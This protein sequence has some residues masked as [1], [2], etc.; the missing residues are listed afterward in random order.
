MITKKNQIKKPYTKDLSFTNNQNESSYMA[1]KVN[2]T[3]NLQTQHKRSSSN[4]KKINSSKFLRNT[5]ESKKPTSRSKKPIMGSIITNNIA[6]Q[7]KKS[8]KGLHTKLKTDIIP[9][10]PSEGNKPS[11]IPNSFQVIKKPFIVKT[12]KENSISE[13]I[14]NL[15]SD[16]GIESTPQYAMEYI[17]DIYSNLL[18]EEKMSPLKP[19]FG[20]MAHQGEINEQMRAILIDWII[21]VHLKFHFNEETLYLTIRIIDLYLSLVPILRANLQLLGV[22][23]L[24]IACKEEEI[25]FP[26]IKEYVYITDNAYTKEQILAME[27]HVLKV[28]QFNI[29]SPSPL[30]FYEIISLALGFDK[31]LFYFGRFLME[32]FIIDY[33][34]T[35]YSASVIASSCAYLV[36]KVF[37]IDNYQLC[38]DKRMYNLNEGETRNGV[39]IIKECAK[40]ICYFVDLLNK[41][42][43]EATKK[44]YSTDA[45]YNVASLM[46]ISK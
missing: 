32:S 13:L 41:G 21:D 17:P 25:S 36:M 19:T 5:N 12:Q 26:H 27:F 40:D 30:R 34:I 11:G 42:K 6:L 9:Y 45:L 23:A 8:S 43:L 14:Q 24:F 16:K 4:F 44:K 22:T 20:Y 33:R 15:I 3:M 1:T 38:Y 10:I 28:I 7:A 46:F 35:K 18:L 29:V 2:T 37:K 39:E 31:K